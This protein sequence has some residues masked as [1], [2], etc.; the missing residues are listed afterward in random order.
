MG[1]V[2][3]PGGGGVKDSPVSSRAAP[4]MVTIIGAGPVGL[5]L[6]NWLCRWGIR[7]EL[8]EQRQEFNRPQILYMSSEFWR[9]VPVEVQEALGEH[10]GVCHYDQNPMLCSKSSGR[11]VNLL[12]GAFQTQLMA[13]LRQAYPQLFSVV[14]E[15]ATLDKLQ[16]RLSPSAATAIDPS[17]RINV[18]LVADGGG[19]HSLVHSLWD[20]TASQPLSHR[21]RGGKKE[22]QAFQHILASHAAVVTFRASVDE[23]QAGRQ[24]TEQLLFV[25]EPKQKASMAF[26]TLPDTAYIGVQL[27]ADTAQALRQFPPEQL[28]KAFLRTTEGQ[29]Y[30]TTQRKAGYRNVRGEQV[31]VF[32]IELRSARQFHYQMGSTHYFLIGDAAFTTHFFTGSGMNKGL[33]LGQQLLDLIFQR[34]VSE[35]GS[36]ER[37]VAQVRDFMRTT[38][39]PEWLPDIAGAIAVCCNGGDGERNVTEAE[40]ECIL[41]QSRILLDQ[42]AIQ[43]VTSPH[44]FVEL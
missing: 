19:R 2:Q 10:G 16:E 30:L 22:E 24:E 4:Y 42:D 37:M 27:R 41:Q 7:V 38:V 18:V 31:S 28:M 11:Y 36:Y 5:M 20:H 39:V 12:L 25:G 14:G 33:E 13:Y 29:V 40:S 32:P 35:W 34:P 8:W 23:L 43:R 21:P 6:A 44:V 17:P 3:L 15:W 26:R 1:N 9:L